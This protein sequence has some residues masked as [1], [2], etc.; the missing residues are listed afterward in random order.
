LTISSQA[1]RGTAVTFSV[2]TATMSD[3]LAVG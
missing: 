1:G 2:L 3:A